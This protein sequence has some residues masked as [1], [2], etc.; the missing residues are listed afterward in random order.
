LNSQACLL[1]SKKKAA[2]LQPFLNSLNWLGLHSHT[3]F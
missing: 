1:I 3:G 2:K